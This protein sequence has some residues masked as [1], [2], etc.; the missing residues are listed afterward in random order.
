MKKRVIL[1]I[2]GAALSQDA[3]PAAATLFAKLSVI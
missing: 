2:V 3:V 1:L